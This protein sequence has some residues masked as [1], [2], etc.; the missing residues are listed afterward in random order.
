MEAQVYFKH[1]LFILDARDCQTA[2]ISSSL[3]VFFFLSSKLWIDDSLH[4]CV[5]ICRLFCTESKSSKWKEL[6]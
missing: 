6:H 5:H 4:L 3:Y 1:F 2:L